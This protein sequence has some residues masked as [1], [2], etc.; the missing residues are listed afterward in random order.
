MLLF[1]VIYT[2]SLITIIIT[3]LKL[4]GALNKWFLGT[5]VFLLVLIAVLFKFFLTKKT[6]QAIINKVGKN[7]VELETDFDLLA[8]TRKQKH[9]LEGK[10]KVKKGQKVNIALKQGFLGQ[11]KPIKIIKK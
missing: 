11:V 4:D 1:G 9:V 5:S 10:F 8:S 6:G 7:F 2:I 3:G